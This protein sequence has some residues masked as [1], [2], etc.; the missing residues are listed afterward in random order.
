MGFING[1]F[2]RAA[3]LA[4]AP[5]LE[6]RDRCNAVVLNWILSSLSQDIYLGHVFSDNVESVWKELDETYDIIDGTKLID[7]G[8][9]LK[10]VQFLMGLDNIYQPIRSSLLTREILPEVKDA[11]VITCGLKG[12]TIERCFEIIGYPPGFKRNPN[13]KINGNFNNK[14]NNAD[15]KG[16]SMGNNEL[17]TPTG[18]LSFTNERV[19]KL[20]NLLNDKFGSTAYANMVVIKVS[21]LS[22]NQVLE[23]LK[24]SLNLFNI[25]HNSPY[26]VYHKA[27]QT[28]DAF[29]ISDR[30]STCL[31]IS[32]IW[33][34]EVPIEWRPSSVLNGKSPFS[35]VYGREPNLH[36]K[37]F[38]CLCFAAVVKGSDKFSERFE[39]CVL[40]GY[41]SEPINKGDSP[42]RPNDDEEDSSDRDGKVHHLEQGYILE[43]PGNDEDNSVTPLDENNNSKGNIGLTD[44]A[45]RKWNQK[46]SEALLEAGFVQSKNDHSLFI[47]NEE[48]FSLYLLVYVD[49]LVITGSDVKEIESFKRPVTT[50]L[51]ENIILSHKETEFDKFLLNITS[52]QKLI[53]YRCM[54]FTTCE[55]IWIV[56]V[57]QDF[58][59]NNLILANLYCDN[60]SAIQ[61]AA[62]PVMHEKTKHIDIDVHLA[63][64]SF[65]HNALTKNWNPPYKFKW[66]EKTV[67]VTVGSSKTTTERYMKNYKNVSQDIRNQLDA[68]AEVVW[69]ILTGIDNDI[70]S[71]VDACPNAC[72]IW[73]AIER[74]KQVKECQKMLWAKDAAYHKEKMLL[75]KQEEAR[76]QLSVEQADWRDDT[77]DEPEDQEL[78]ARH[79]YMEKTQ[80]VLHIEHP[81]QPEFVNDTYLEEQG[82]TNITINSLDM[83]T[84]VET[85]DQDDGGLAKERDSLAS[86]IEKLKCKIDDRVI[87]T[88]SVSRPQ[89]K[90]NQLEDR[91]MHNNSKRKKKQIEDH[92]RNFKFS[93]NKT[94]VTACNDSLNAKTLNANFV[95]VTCRK[96]VLNDNHDMCVL[97][98]INGMNTRTKQSIVVP[99]STREP[100]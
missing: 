76:Y 38:G 16:N 68:K 33:M 83:S 77:N 12:H 86:F 23:L 36:L 82:D 37:S 39:K 88:T 55:I 10:L 25:D 65:Q 79:L 92:H 56:K 40:V 100:K 53:E 95:R 97:H 46:L 7:H 31:V 45:P 66:T 87:P 96:C 14:S 35:L 62:N 19:L 6:K 60:E 41:A 4:S 75:C 49:D 74:L 22:A 72:E 15:S 5:L 94:Y 8:K 58:R 73:K 43:Q 50:P 17:K 13:L 9:L 27:K 29:S 91:V 78:E 20:M 18:T 51:P 57:L 52:Y 99:I 69:V 84:N 70:Y 28:R 42:L 2:V 11:F 24:D 93:S 67:P 89:P 64:G 85:V 3:Y 48:K 30:K 81:E 71:T 90:S 47:K 61:I 63:L 98:Y 54:A 21:F 59:L 44:E 34:F 32:F 1:T 80:E 26:E